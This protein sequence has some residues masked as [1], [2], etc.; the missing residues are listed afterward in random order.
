MPPHT[1]VLCKNFRVYESESLSIRFLFLYKYDMNSVLKIQV[2]NF[3]FLITAQTHL[4]HGR[5][6]ASWNFNC[7]WFVDPTFP[8]SKP[9]V[10]L[11]LC[12]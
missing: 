4:E 7:V 1:N 11:K 5:H 10:L 6:V 8:E 9:K 3:C 2:A 12:V